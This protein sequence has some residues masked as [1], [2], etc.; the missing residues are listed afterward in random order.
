[1]RRALLASSC[2]LVLLGLSTF[3]YAVDDLEW[4]QVMAAADRF[5]N[6]AQYAQAEKRYEKALSIARA[7]KLE[8]KTLAASQQGMANCLRLLNKP[9][10]AEPLYREVLKLRQRSDPANSIGTAQTLTGL[11]MVLTQLRKIDEA[12]PFLLRSYAIWKNSPDAEPCPVGMTMNALMV[13]YGRQREYGKA[14]VVGMNAIAMLKKAIEKEAVGLP[15]SERPLRS[16]ECLMLARIIGNLADM[17]HTQGRPGK[18]EAMYE[19]AIPALRLQVGDDSLR[20]AHEEERLARLYLEDHKYDRAEP[21]CKHII[22]VYEKGGAT[23]NRDLLGALGLYEAVL[24]MLNR[25]AEAESLHQ[26]LE[27]AKRV[28][29]LDAELQNK[30]DPVQAWQQDLDEAMKAQVE[31]RTA[32]QESALL[33]ALRDSEDFEAKDFRRSHTLSLVAGFYEQQGKFAQAE[34]YMS[35]AL[36]MAEKR[37]G[38]DSWETQTMLIRTG[39][40]YMNQQKYPPAEAALQRAVAL[41]EKLAQHND[42][43]LENAWRVLALCYSSEQQY[44]KAEALYL[45]SLQRAEAVSGPDSTNLVASLAQLAAV[46]EA[47]QRY[48]KAEAVYRRWLGILEKQQ[49]ANSPQLLSPLLS[50]KAVLEK[51]NRADEAEWIGARVQSI[52]ATKH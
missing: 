25:T 14:E 21:L 36:T 6:Q 34:P 33:R 24:R 35:R 20:V 47:W 22:G 41:A 4:Y 28:R 42:P 8:E 5:Y 45:R 2:L 13:L 10:E 9:A 40:M 27:A 26:R 1:M 19:E 15:A 16:D 46:Y 38:R 18:A 29:Q 52:S 12:E 49:G 7:H 32:D 11:G 37:F 23:V 44:D 50:L 17:Y 48:D 30:R 51:E 31:R 39:M 3:A 43:R